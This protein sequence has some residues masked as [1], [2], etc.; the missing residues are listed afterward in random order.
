MTFDQ[1]YICLEFTI[2]HT[3]IDQKYIYQKY[4]L[5][6]KKIHSYKY[7]EQRHTN[8]DKCT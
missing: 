6:F 1:K 7:F 8:V 2:A 3:I 5:P 4:N